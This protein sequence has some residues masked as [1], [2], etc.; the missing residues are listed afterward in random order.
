M[1]GLLSVFG[2][3]VFVVWGFVMLFEVSGLGL[4]GLYGLLVFG[5]VLVVM[6]W[7]F[8]CYGCFVMVFGGGFEF[9]CLLKGISILS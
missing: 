2:L 1:G 6:G 5:L 8:V 9:L 3:V 4:V 7:W